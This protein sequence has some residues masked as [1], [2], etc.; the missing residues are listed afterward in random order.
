MVSQLEK[1][2]PRILWNPK[3]TK[4]PL[5]DGPPDESVPCHFILLRHYPFL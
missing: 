1:K 3:A 5:F 4:N 2:I